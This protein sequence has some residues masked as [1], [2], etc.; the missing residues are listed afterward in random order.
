MTQK[1]DFLSNI[2]FNYMQVEGA[3]VVMKD[4]VQEILNDLEKNHNQSLAREIMNRNANNGNKE[5][6]FYRGNK[7]TYGEMF[8]HIREYATSLKALG[9]KVRK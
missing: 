6:I 4:N 9:Y 7:I 2:C 8:K 3:Y 1:L 5:A